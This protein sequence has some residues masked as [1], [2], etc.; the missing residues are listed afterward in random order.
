MTVRHLTRSDQ[1]V[2]LLNRFGHGY[3][4]SRIS[5][6]ETA[7]AEKNPH[8]VERN[9]YLPPNIDS[10]SPV[11]FCWDNNDLQE[12]TA[13]GAGTTHCTNGIV[14]QRKTVQE[15]VQTET[16]HEDHNQYRQHQRSI[17]SPPLPAMHYVSTV[18]E[19]PPLGEY[20]YEPIT[21]SDPEV[22]FAGL[23]DTAWK[24][25]RFSDKECKSLS[26]RKDSD[27]QLVASWSDFNSS[28]TFSSPESVIGYLPVIPSSP[29]EAA[30]VYEL[31]NR[32]CA[33]SAK[34][35]Q[36][37]TIITLDQ[38]IY[39]K[40]QEIKWKNSEQFKSVVLMMGGFHICATFLAVIGKRYGDA[41]LQ[42]ILV[43]SGTGASGSVSAVFEG[44]H[45]NQ[46]MRAHKVVWEVLSRL[47]WREFQDYMDNTGDLPFS[48]Q[49][50]AGRVD[51]LRRDQDRETF[52][53]LVR[54]EDFKA[55]IDVYRTFCEQDHG[56]MFAFWSYL[57]MVDLLLTF[58]RSLREA[59]WT[60]HCACL[61]LMLPYMFA[62]DRTNYARYMTMYWC[63][64]SAL[65]QTH[66]EAYRQLMNGNFA[67]QRSSSNSFSQ[68]AVDQAI[69]QTINRDSKG[70]GG[71]VGFSLRPGAVHKWIVTT[72]ERADVTRA[73]KVAAGMDE[74]RKANIINK[75]ASLTSEMSVKSV[76]SLLSSW[77]NPFEPSDAIFNI[78]SGVTATAE[79]ERDCLVALKIGE[80]GLQDFIESRL[81]HQS[82]GFYDRLSQT[83]LK[84]FST[85]LKTSRHKTNKGK[86]SLQADR[87]L[88][89]RMIVIAQ[90]R[91]L[92]MRE[93]FNYELGPIP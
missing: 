58:V 27:L 69:E 23:K 43:E 8:R 86:V 2:T 56:P 9:V 37:Y 70:R 81:Q 46:A 12:E 39:C 47:R 45:Y 5:E 67:V 44:R 85:M 83:K 40:T 82:V 35:G 93:L 42:D 26:N 1:I 78:A 16:L 66:P 41:G 49:D 3:S 31:L 63:E 22:Q 88:F 91:L 33:L 57:S 21:F 62:F 84:T 10:N 17:Q 64:M 65:R 25:L 87:N 28:V 79:L 13:S 92:D 38:A 76:L 32:S 36:S 52:I 30:T 75:K 89:A 11:V 59:N 60:L 55:L 74:S 53:D 18:R 34:L 29:T 6:Y 54:S 7:I 80:K 50:I 20:Q 24:I 4:S 68:V 72:H 51:K 73:C 48:L 71:I 90:T 61:R 19:G 14:I 15:Q 77:H